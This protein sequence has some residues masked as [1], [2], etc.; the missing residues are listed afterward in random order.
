MMANVK[1]VDFTNVKNA[2]PAFITIIIMLLSYSITEG[3][4][5]GIITFAFIDIIIYLI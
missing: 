4:G 5:M 2:V 3:I 1:D